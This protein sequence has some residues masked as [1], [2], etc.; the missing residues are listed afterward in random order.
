MSTSVRQRLAAGS[1]GEGNDEQSDAKGNRGQR[2]RLTESS[3]SADQRDHPEVHTG[4]DE[5][6]NEVV[7]ADAVARTAVPYCSGSQR[8]KMAKLPPK[9]PKAK[10]HRDERMQS[11]RP[12]IR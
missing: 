6:P 9:K 8:L 5:R 2:K 12:S 4:S 11:P 1:H 7:K 3:H 10:Q